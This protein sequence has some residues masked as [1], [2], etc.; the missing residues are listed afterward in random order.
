MGLCH[1]R[2]ELRRGDQRDQAALRQAFE[3]AWATA[4]LVLRVLSA[5]RSSRLHGQGE[6]PQEGV[7]STGLVPRRRGLQRERDV[8]REEGVSVPVLVNALVLP[9]RLCGVVEDREPRRPHR[10]RSCT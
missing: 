7:L 5:S 3:R 4:R 9:F 10:S 1:G 2:D 6:G 8:H